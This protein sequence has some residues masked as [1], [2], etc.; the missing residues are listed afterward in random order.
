MKLNI[1]YCLI[2][3]FIIVLLYCC[4]G[5]N[6]LEGLDATKLGNTSQ[7]VQS[8]GQKYAKQQYAQYQS[9]LNADDLGSYSDPKCNSSTERWSADKKKMYI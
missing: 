5:T 2:G 7:A 1:N 6:L 8:A 4:L 9:N 3:L